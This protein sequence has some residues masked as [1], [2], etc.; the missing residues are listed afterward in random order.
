MRPDSAVICLRRHLLQRTL[1]ALAAVVLSVAS[2][3]AA[4]T[5]GAAP[6]DPI[7]AELMRCRL[8]LKDLPEANP[9]SQAIREISGPVLGKSEAALAAGRRLAALYYLSLARRNVAAQASLPPG[10]FEGEGALAALEEEWKRRGPVLSASAR[11]ALTQVPAAVR[12]LGE[13]ALAEVKPYYDASLEYGRSA[14]TVYGWFYLGAAQSQLEF[15]RLCGRLEAPGAPAPP[16]LRALAAELD[17]LEG[18]MLA[19]YRPPAS[20]D[21]HPQFIRMS[22]VLKQARELDRAGLRYGALY[23]YLDARLRVSRLAAG[24]RSIAPAEA[25]E[26]A[27]A[28][29]TRLDHDPVDHSLGRLYVELALAASADADP[30]AKGGEVARAVFD[31]VLPSYLAAL[32]PARPVP[33]SPAPAVTVTLVRWP[34]T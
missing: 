10:P 14:G 3:L 5:E 21:S 6:Q 15:A 19:L 4:G 24:A 29:A 17:A 16:P 27:R 34:Y 23:L 26:R 20:I 11:P 12:A 13:V 22:A 18:E 30:N 33:P 9:D 32:E 8:L 1:P 7:E 31:A 28:A 25:L 2:L